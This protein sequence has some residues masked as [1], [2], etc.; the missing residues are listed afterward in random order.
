[1]VTAETIYE[2]A[3]ELDASRLRQAYDFLE[4]LAR[5]QI[6]DF[7]EMIEEKRGYFPETVLEPFDQKP[8]Y[9]TRTLTVEEMDAAVEYEAGLRR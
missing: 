4:F 1:M 2:K 3:K 9:S 6:S 8:P 5:G 7:Q